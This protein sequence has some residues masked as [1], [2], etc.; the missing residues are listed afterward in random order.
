MQCYCKTPENFAPHTK[1]ELNQNFTA[2]IHGKEFSAAICK[3]Y[4]GLM[5][6]GKIFGQAIAFVII[7]INIV[8]KTVIIKLVTWIKEDT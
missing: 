8:L 2:T 6:F 4:H 3:E 5:I 7:A 1:W